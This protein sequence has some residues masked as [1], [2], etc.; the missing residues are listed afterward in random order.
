MSTL[1]LLTPLEVSARLKVCLK[2]V[3]NMLNS[4]TLQPRRLPGLRAVR[5][6]PDDLEKLIED[7]K[8]QSGSM[9]KA[10]TKSSLAK[11]DAEFIEF[12]QKGRQGNKP[13][14]QK[15]SSGEKSLEPT[16]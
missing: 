5:V 3:Y 15:T 14:K 4:G 10:N 6:H 1:D 8:C 9:K 2:T 7:A 13:R 16:S 12:C 11:G